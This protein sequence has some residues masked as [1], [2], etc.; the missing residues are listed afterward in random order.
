MISVVSV[1]GNSAKAIGV[2]MSIGICTSAIGD[3]VSVGN[4]NIVTVLGDGGLLVNEVE[5]SDISPSDTCL[6]TSK[7]GLFSDMVAIPR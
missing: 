4:A 6:V 3:S 2:W 5:S 7:E 1:K